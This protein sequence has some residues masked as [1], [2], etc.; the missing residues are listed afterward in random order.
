MHSLGNDFILIERANLNDAGGVDVIKKLSHR[1]TGIGFDRAII[2]ESIRA[3]NNEIRVSF[4]NSDGT[5]IDFCCNG[6]KV[7]AG[8]FHYLTT[9]KNFNINICLSNGKV[10]KIPTEILGNGKVKIE[11]TK[12]DYEFV[13]K[14]ELIL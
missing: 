10:E 7:V 12:P 9:L 8:Y 11:T 6:L 5:H 14:G 2:I 4:Y 1:F 13:F 3:N